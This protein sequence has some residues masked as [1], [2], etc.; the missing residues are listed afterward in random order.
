M[1]DTE[2]TRGDLMDSVIVGGGPKFKLP[3]LMMGKLIRLGD[4]IMCMSISDGF[5]T[6]S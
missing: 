4:V 2:I 6:A 1:V 3:L 5:L